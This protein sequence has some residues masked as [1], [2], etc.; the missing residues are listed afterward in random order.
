VGEVPSGDRLR[1]GRETLSGVDR[2][3]V[4]CCLSVHEEDRTEERCCWIGRGEILACEETS[5]GVR[6]S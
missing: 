1:K 5:G 6:G 2:R 4:R 3:M